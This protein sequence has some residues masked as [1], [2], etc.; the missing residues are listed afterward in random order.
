M[1]MQIKKLYALTLVAGLLASSQI[2]AAGFEKNTMWS[3]KYAAFAGAANDSVRGSEG[4]YFNPAGMAASHGPEISLNLSPTWDKFQGPVAIANQTEESKTRFSPIYGATASYGLMDKV[5]V[6]IGTYVSGG[7][8]AFFMDKPTA[9][10]P[11]GFTTN[12]IADLNIIEYALGVAVSPVENLRIGATWRILHVTGNLSSTLFPTG[13][14]AAPANVSVDDFSGT[15]YNGFKLGAQWDNSERK[16]GLGA[17]WR[18]PVT[19]T[20]NGTQTTRLSGALGGGTTTTNGVPVTNTFPSQISL[21]GY[22]H[23]TPGF[24]GFLDYAWTQYA[25]DKAIVVGTTAIAQG[26]HNMHNVRVGGEWMMT[27]HTAL[28]A[29]YGW[30]SQ[31]TPDDIAR[32]TFSSPG[33]GNTVTV[34]AG[35]NSGGLELSGALEYSWAS[36]TGTGNTAAATLPGEFSTKAYAVHLGVGY[37]L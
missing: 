10:V 2:F 20:V 11:A 5:A 18:T 30:T 26:W 28:R 7:T 37:H 14:A 3:G 27:E 22:Y 36:G 15:R 21:G 13:A 24:T 9:S 16:W 8:K 4:L 6:G 17:S 23:F 34:G 33:H 19:F 12:S 35:T 32:A 31:V 1:N 25:V 29:G